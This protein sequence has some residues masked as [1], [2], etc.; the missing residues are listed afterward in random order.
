MYRSYL[1]TPPLEWRGGP[2]RGTGFL[3]SGRSMRNLINLLFFQGVWYVAVLGGE[4]GNQWLGPAGLMLFIIS[5]YYLAET[6]IA[7]YLLAAMAILIGLII[8]TAFFRAGLLV[9][10]HSDPANQFAPAWILVLWANFALTMNGCLKWLQ[11][12]LLLAAV[13]GAIGGPLTYFAGIK[14]GAATAG[15]SMPIILLVIAVTYALITPLFLEAARRL[16]AALEPARNLK[17]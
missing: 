6:A 2:S 5:H 10:T 17:Q 3:F 7:D 16:P 15:T 14:L 12:R 1:Y 9:Y 13:L 8:E 4:T 11:K